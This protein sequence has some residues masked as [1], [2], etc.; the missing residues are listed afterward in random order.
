MISIKDFENQNAGNRL[1]FVVCKNLIIEKNCIIQVLINN[2]TIA[3]YF[4]CL[5]NRK[6]N[7]KVLKK[8]E[9]KVFGKKI[10]SENHS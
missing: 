6:F 4:E 3:E 5:K 1:G 7:G 8:D 2:A 10:I 9:K